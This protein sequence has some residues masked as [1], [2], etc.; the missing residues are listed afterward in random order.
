MMVAAVEGLSESEEAQM[1]EEPEDRGDIS[2]CRGGSDFR[3]F[4]RGAFLGFSKRVSSLNFGAGR[5][6]MWIWR[7]RN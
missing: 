3:P 7:D 6:G 5:G 1:V 4:G 2:G